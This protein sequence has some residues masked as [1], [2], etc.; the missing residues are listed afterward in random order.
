M[1]NPPGDAAMLFGDKFAFNEELVFTLKREQMCQI[2]IE[3][4]IM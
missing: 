3:D 2:V 1:R 4:E